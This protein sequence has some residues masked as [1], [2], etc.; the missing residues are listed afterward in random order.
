MLIKLLKFE[1]RAT[2]R[3]L[4]PLYLAAIIISVISGIVFNHNIGA[5]INVGGD[6]FINFALCFVIAFLFGITVT[7]SVVIS[8]I[9][10]IQ[11]FRKNLLGNEGY[12]MH[13]L[14]VS[15]N[16]QIA[17]KL[18]TAVIYEIISV[19]VAVFSWV[20][21][22]FSMTEVNLSDIVSTL[23]SAF[24]EISQFITG[25]ICVYIF[26]VIVGMIVMLISFNLKIYAAMSIGYSKNSHR[27]M[28]SVGFY[29]LFYIITQIINSC[30]TNFAI[31]NNV[32]GIYSHWFLDLSVVIYIIYSIVFW[33]ITSYFLR[34][35]LNLQ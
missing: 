17:A 26:E 30:I 7:A 4:F 16:S 14:P 33:F 29:I 10:T 9:M 12:I 21:V 27:V 18:I 34:K 28:K 20:I 35:K 5:N 31:S 2:G 1:C 6:G 19:C 25:E 23:F 8:Y 32:L 15:M 11:R 13:T 24:S 22:V 3:V